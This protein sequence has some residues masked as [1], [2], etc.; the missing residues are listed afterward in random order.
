MQSVAEFMRQQLAFFIISDVPISLTQVTSL[1]N[2]EGF[3][4][5]LTRTTINARSSHDDWTVTTPCS[6]CWFFS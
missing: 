4:L 2:V 6:S 1:A 3:H 5:T